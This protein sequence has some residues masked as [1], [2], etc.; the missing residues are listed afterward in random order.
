M[1]GTHPLL[2]V[3]TDTKFG[4]IFSFLVTSLP[5]P[6]PQGVLQATVSVELSLNPEL[7][8]FDLGLVF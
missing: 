4:T 5:S 6:D 7:Q 8:L 3:A 1:F 2:A